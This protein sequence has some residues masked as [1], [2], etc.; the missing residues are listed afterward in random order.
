V[1]T[2]RWRESSAWLPW[3]KPYENGAKSTRPVEKDVTFQGGNEVAN[4]GNELRREEIA[5]LKHQIAYLEA[6]LEPD[7]PT[8]IE[9][10]AALLKRVLTTQVWPDD[11]MSRMT[12]MEL[13]QEIKQFLKGYE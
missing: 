8:P 12:R 3:P 7:P 6:G 4:K 9:Q 13:A 1:R 5:R 11:F 10:A 2:S